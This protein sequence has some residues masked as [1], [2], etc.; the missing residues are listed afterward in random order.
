MREHTLKNPHIYTHT[1]IP[2]CNLF[3]VLIQFSYF[4]LSLLHEEVLI[5]SHIVF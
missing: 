1:H 3:I 5:P 4:A 2:T